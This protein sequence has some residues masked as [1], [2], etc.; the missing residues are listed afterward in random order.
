M[1]VILLA[2]AAP[3]VVPAISLWVLDQMFGVD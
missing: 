3:I 1:L 2:L